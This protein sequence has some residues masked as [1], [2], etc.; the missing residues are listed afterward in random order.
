VR[1]RSCWGVGTGVLATLQVALLLTLGV[2]GALAAGSTIRVSVSTAGAQAT[3]GASQQP[4]ISDDGT[5]VVFASAA[6]DLVEGDGNGRYD[7]FVRDRAAGTTKLVSE[8]PD[9]RP[10]NGDSGVGSHAVALSADGRYVAFTS[11]ASNLVD[12]DTN[13]TVDVFVR[14]LLEGT[15]TRVSRSSEGLQGNGASD[16][17]SISDDGR[18][19]AFRSLASNLLAG[20]DSNTV[21]DIFRHD[22]ATGSTIRV[23]VDSAGVE[24]N[25]TSQM[26]AISGDGRY[27]A[28]STTATNLAGGGAG[29]GGFQVVRKDT[30]EAGGVA[31][32]SRTPAGA[33]GNGNSYWPELSAD[34]SRVAFFSDAADLVAG[35]ANGAA[36]V[37]LHSVAGAATVIASR[38]DVGGG[39]GNGSAAAPISMSADGR[40]VAFASAASNLVGGDTNAAQDVF[41]RDVSLGR[42][43]RVSL[44]A[45][46]GQGDATSSMPAL[47]GDG[48]SVAFA[49]LATNL[50]GDDTNANSDIFV[51]DLAGGGGGAPPPPG[52][53]H[54]YTF[55]EPEGTQAHDSA[56]GADGQISGEASRVP[57]LLGRGAVATQAT[58]DSYIEF[59]PSVL[60]VGTA[61]FTVSLWLKRTGPA[62]DHS[63]VFGDRTEGSCGNY[64]SIRVR[65]DRNT[66]GGEIGQDGGCTNY[67]SVDGGI[68]PNGEWHLMT[69]T[70][71]GATIRMYRDGALAGTATAAAVANLQSLGKAFRIGR[72]I[73]DGCCPTL[74]SSQAQYDDLRI[75]N[76]AL[77]PAEVSA[78]ASGASGPL[79]VNTADDVND[80]VCTIVHCSLRE[81]LIGANANPGPDTIGFAIG[82]GLQT[83]RPT[84]PLPAITDSVIVDGRSQPGFAGTPI[85][86][87]DGRN[88]GEIASGLTSSVP[89]EI[90]GLIV[91]RFARNGIDLGGGSVLEGNWVGLDASGTMAAG[92]GWHGIRVGGSGNTIGG[93]TPGARNVVS[94]QSGPSGSNVFVGGST[95]RIVGNYVGTN[96]A[97]TA[98]VAGNRFGVWV[99]GDD[100]DVLGNLISGNQFGV[101]VYDAS[102]DAAHTAIQRNTIGL[103]AAR[104]GPVRNQV[105][106]RIEA[107]EPDTLIGG[108]PAAANVI[109]GNDEGIFL[110]GGTGTGT[111]I[112]SNYVGTTP[113]RVDLGNTS[114][115]I[116]VAGPGTV[117]GGRNAGAGNVV[118]FN[119]IGV[120]VVVDGSAEIA[121]NSIDRNDNLG[122]DLAGT[123]GITA[124]DALDADLGANRQQ[125]FP[126]LSRAVRGGAMTTVEGEL[127]SEPSKSV[128]IDVYSSP[129]CDPSG[130]GEGRTWIASAD[131]ATDAAGV[132]TF[133][134]AFAGSLTVGSSITATATSAGNTSE[135]SACRVLEGAPDPG[136]LRV[137]THGIDSLD[138]AEAFSTTSWQLVHE[139]CAGLVTYD[140][141]PGSPAGA[142]VPEVAAGMPTVSNGG[143]TYEFTLRGDFRFQPSGET[144]TPAAF[145]RSL[146]RALRPDG[147]S[148]GAPYFDDVVGA[149]AY[150]AGT[151]ERIS[152]VETTATTLRITLAAPN[153]TL[154]AR[155]ATPF[156]CAVPP[157]T[158][159]HPSAL[160]DAAGP[161]YVSSYAPGESVTLTAN[162]AY[163]GHRPRE[164]GAIEVAIT[165]DAA[166]ALARVE[167]GAADYTASGVPVAERG[168]LGTAFGPASPAAAA[169]AQRYFENPSAL[170]RNLALNTERTLFADAR[171]RRAV[172]IAVN[173]E[174]LAA[175]Q[176]D[177]PSDQ[178]I[179]PGVAGFVDHDLYPLD[180][181]AEDVARA[182]ALVEA[183]G[184]VGALA[185][186]YTCASP[187][188]VQVAAT[189]Q[190][191]LAAIGITVSVEQF[192]RATQ[193]AKTQTRGEPFDLSY[194]GWGADYLDPA[195]FTRDLL[196][197]SKISATGSVN[198]SYFDDPYWNARM[199]AA[200]ALSGDARNR[201]FADLDRDLGRDAAPMVAYASG[202]R[203]DFFAERIGCQR[204]SAIF[205][206]ELGA[207]CL[208]T[209]I[210]AATSLS[211]ASTSVPAGVAEVRLA[212]LPITELQLDF[213]SAI[214]ST[215]LDSTPLDSTPLDSTPLDSTP[216]DSI[217]LDSTGL[218]DPKL[219]TA[220][221]QIFLSSIPLATA[222]GW[223]AVLVGTP[224]AGRPLQTVSLG[225][226]L[227]LRPLP[228]QIDPPAGSAARALTLGDLDAGTSALGR[229]STLAIALGGL[230]VDA[231]RLPG[232]SSNALANWCAALSGPPVNCAAGNPQ[233]LSG[234]SILALDLRGTPLDS[235]P[236][237]STPLDSIDL[238]NV[239]TAVPLDSTPLDSINMALS[240]LD[241]TPLRPSL[242]AVGAIAAIP[243]DSI[244]LDSTGRSP[245]HA[246]LVA[247]TLH[248]AAIVACAAAGSCPAG[249]TLGAAADA[250]L[251]LPSAR[252]SDVGAA[253][254]ALYTLGDL[255]SYGEAT[256][257]DIWAEIGDLTLGELMRALVPLSAYPWESLQLDGLPLQQIA[258]S[259]GT[260]AF[261]AQIR[262]SG[263]GVAPG[264]RFGA[265]AAVRLPHGWR[266]VPGSTQLVRV[267]GGEPARAV[268]DPAIVDDVA[269]WAVDLAANA[270]YQLVFTMRAGISLGLATPASADVRAEGGAKAASAP[271]SVQVGDTFE[272]NDTPA[273]AADLRPDSLVFSFVARA[274]DVDYFRF[275]APAPGSRVVVHLS[276]L[277]SDAD[278]VLYD[279]VSA[280]LRPQPPLRAPPSGTI[281]PDDGF[282]LAHLDGVLQPERLQD[283]PLVQGRRVAG[284]SI[285]REMETET[286]STISNYDGGDFLVQV[287]P[288]NRARSDN[289]YVLRV[290]VF[291]PPR[292]TSCPPPAF[293][294]AGSGVQG[295]LPAALPSGV[296]TLFLV[297]RKRLGDT[298]GP[299][300]EA[301][302]Q[303]MRN[304]LPALATLQH[305]AFIAEVDGD[306]DAAAA[307]A[308]WDAN[309]CS[310]ARA[311]EVV[312]AV[313]AIVDRARAASPG[314]RHVVLVGGDRIVPFAR[315]RDGTVVANESEFASTYAAGTSIRGALAGENVLS[316]DPYGSVAP[317]GADRPIY[318][319]LLAVGRL[320]E[321]PAEIA[322]AVDQFVL[323]GGRLDPATKQS[324]TTGYDFLTDGAAAVD[325]ELRGLSPGGSLLLNDANWTG[326][327]LA[328]ALLGPTPPWLAAIN[329]HFDP[330]RALPG[331]DDAA[332]TQADLFDTSR[333][334]AAG[335]SKLTGTLVFSMGC[336]AGLSVEDVGI[337]TGYADWAQTFGAQRASF[338]G[339]TGYGYG[340]SKVIAYGEELMRAFAAELRGARDI[341]HALVAAKQHYLASLVVPGV[342][343][344]KS[345]AEATFYG[346][347]MYSIG[348]VTRALSATEA[349]TPAS[350]EPVT[351]LP[352][353][354]V[355]FQ[356]SLGAAGPAPR[357]LR[358]DT[359]RGSF[360][361]VDG[362]S[363]VT[364][365]RPVQPFAE[366][367]VTA[368][369]ATLVAHG[370]IVTRL[371]STD[372][373][374][375]GYFAR[376]TI[377]DAAREP[378]IVFGDVAWPS[379][380]QGIGT[381]QS[382]AGR[383]QLL[384]LVPG[385]FFNDSLPDA[386]GVGFQRLF[387]DIGADVV[388]S[389]NADFVAP[390]LSR[391]DGAVV[392]TTAA[393]S[394]CATDPLGGAGD[395]K[396][397]LVLYRDDAP[398]ASVWRRAELVRSGTTCTWTGGG[399]AIG[400][401][402][403][404]L[405]QA[406]DD[407]GNVAVS[408]FK[409]RYYQAVAQPALPAGVT[410]GV[411][412]T[413]DAGWYTG[414]VEVTL[415]ATGGGAVE[416]ALDG[417]ALRRYTGPVSVTGTGVHTLE[418][419]SSAG[420]EGT[421]HIPIDATDP[422]VDVDFPAAGAVFAPGA[423]GTVAFTCRDSGS[424]IASCAGSVANG[425]ALATGAVGEH[426]I[427][428][429]ATD[430]VGHRTEVART[431]R[432]E[433]PFTGFLIPVKNPPA[434]N[435][436]RQGDIIPVRFG[437]GGNRGTG[438]SVLEPGYPVSAPYPCGT[439]PQLTA[440]DATVVPFN[441]GLVYVPLLKQYVY[442]WQTS[443]LWPN[444]C[445]QFVLKLRDGTYHRLNVRFEKS[446]RRW[447]DD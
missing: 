239:P 386:A 293:S 192:S 434:V 290:Q 262:L 70:R 257:G 385:Q 23:S 314:L 407:A 412:G 106:I 441:L 343:D 332:G 299:G 338:L 87:V 270:D 149:A 233:S 207:L 212:D 259:G 294:F 392:G 24:A 433:W 46:D 179:P 440:G 158:P 288:Y 216:L 306:A 367:D 312:R 289:A 186:M 415:S 421:L 168:R 423:A 424:G 39:Q 191:N 228:A 160:P 235:T 264:R 165:D 4:A 339:N 150:R 163:P 145:A 417:G 231:I 7:V 195:N 37:F 313:G 130:N 375:D 156:A 172:N 275:P 308:R 242:L 79:V 3:G 325:A 295:T 322:D 266:F 427:T 35:D 425:S 92:N 305:P 274:D 363:Q 57:G 384:T 113:A 311:N 402:V 65:N 61:D 227:A 193:I 323:F 394:V 204:W 446:A 1:W 226:V 189:V 86:E 315:L 208:R 55:D 50:V 123:P 88:A 224:F 93:S 38:A 444:G 110:N 177:T 148:P 27:V 124:N 310:T 121:G 379:K 278:L 132:A 67:A 340:D 118:M 215:P 153:G 201:A 272:P 133:T 304:Q 169:G 73:E 372:V 25:R 217:P 203:S 362:R 247:E 112:R 89:V 283:V 164:F 284:V 445:R 74:V 398:G 232:S 128:T 206:V 181:G 319:P 94:G 248:P 245:L 175:I 221:D 157:S 356:P 81:A 152:G 365:Y 119:A 11:T 371:N 62:P 134:L 167:S 116:I 105:G 240:P 399:A 436:A 43:A 194:L 426:T 30:A 125:N 34:G 47:T 15:T 162:P 397:V 109:A 66:V 321:T 68:F 48:S 41:L 6:T 80:G 107:T 411:A 51:R 214:G 21:E 122:I 99:T 64:L 32:V 388:Y 170:L 135:F 97:G 389:R 258:S 230:P 198:T 180:P 378:E 190:S 416:Y 154:L 176:G 265:E 222:G 330:R 329:G 285:N 26:P 115:G 241:S 56:G 244:P 320:V 435:V 225:E 159:D 28:F 271:V 437:L 393:F 16:E 364:H 102:G 303:R 418:Y 350:S 354:H 318:V 395:V 341:G 220:L 307:Y 292:D 96:A 49:S 183:A 236:L 345:V 333:V 253:A 353:H 136:T 127:R 173:R 396:R 373:A 268:A 210:T 237:D 273:Q 229:L 413:R 351:G 90:H 144:V 138:P 383:K 406:L 390:E 442:A 75:Y 368:S 346:L 286:I 254:L 59:P 101:Y 205:G 342:Y 443:K 84:S 300:A 277:S 8:S 219:R 182:R 155:L 410:V 279:P 381:Y 171:V 243:L 359:D 129:T 316:D 391:V 142:I 178:Y 347:P 126:V 77:T 78:L 151:T 72:R 42:T 409:A 202:R 223:E 420:V 256:I 234:T 52:L 114:G 18:F 349:V 211:P 328:N 263:T 302:L 44:G 76:K 53:V 213:G 199:D 17:P 337:G 255:R 2:G 218:L 428:V 326:T 22:R 261:T 327:T 29:E 414:G 405:V 137:A 400:T 422:V 403:E 161:Y 147:L 298:Y 139:T 10:A 387:T 69:L 187:A 108:S 252:L 91:N 85:V 267:G 377:D 374:V 200:N 196:H 438:A 376:P 54:H 197:G 40:F 63:D 380:I 344:E 357:L 5:V 251:I 100:N 419:H 309:P 141:A 335:L 358:T 166:A 174:A 331:A 282:D 140:T 71:A 429:V 120:W 430:R 131:G 184:A 401:R 98:A 301:A 12:G 281:L 19:V 143:R 58:R 355:D 324:L 404:Y 20:P 431:Y 334:A 287:S 111:I 146:E 370:A 382:D 352:V 348:V 60:D 249:L 82:T 408:T 36:D 280:P 317:V 209:P 188:C 238:Q 276:H 185:K 297:N 336:H 439:A 31:I 104:T 269:R 366:L 360:W 117:V 246:I 369:D 260:L 45:T 296:D 83:I 291:A 9:H 447:G 432:V 33:P 361:T 103:N 13:E 250:A 95:N 14:D